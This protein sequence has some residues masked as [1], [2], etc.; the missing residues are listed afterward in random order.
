MVR[1]GGGGGGDG[2]PFVSDSHGEACRRALALVVELE[3]DAERARRRL[4]EDGV[5]A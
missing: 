5:A 1:S 4:V 3:W 2:L